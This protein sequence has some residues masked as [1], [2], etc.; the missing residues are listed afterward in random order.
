M[1]RVKPNSENFLPKGIPFPETELSES[2]LCKVASPELQETLPHL[3]R[4]VL[5]SP[6][7]GLKFRRCHLLKTT[8]KKHIL[9]F[10]YSFI[11]FKAALEDCFHF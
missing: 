4:Q 2:K 5:N 3:R 10:I 6:D 1:C 11:F 7:S 8:P 9:Y